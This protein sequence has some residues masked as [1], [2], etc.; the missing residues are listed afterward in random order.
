[1]RWTK[2]EKAF[3][4]DNYKKLSYRE[5][6]A[7]LGRSEL[8]VQSKSAVIGIRISRAWSE[9]HL[10]ILR[11]DYPNRTAA[12]IAA[13]IGR[14]LSAVHGMAKSLGIKK[15]PE[16]LA[17]EAS[18]RISAERN[19]RGN[20]TRFYKGM[21]P[22]SKGT[23]GVCGQHPNSRRTQFKSGSKPHNSVPVGTEIVSTDGYK[24]VKVAEPNVWELVHRRNWEKL[25]GLIPRGMMI[26]FIDGDRMNC[27][28]E[29]L[30]LVTRT[31]HAL[32]N[33]QWDFPA[34]IVPAMAALAE[35]KREIRNAEK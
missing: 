22:W 11:R 25:N 7:R 26:R 21:T 2:E 32:Y 14:G 9:E 30:M 23:K 3:L 24:K 33:S 29:N 5:I 20:P 12:S 10:T 13:E 4:R 34:E 27:S 28:I 15:S 6:A 1:M 19:E 31:E 18:G 17:S 35:L 16:F 8:A